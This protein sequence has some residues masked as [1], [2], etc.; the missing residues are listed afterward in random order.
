[1]WH[2]TE[3]LKLKEHA[4]GDGRAVLEN[5]VSGSCYRLGPVETRIYKA[6]NAQQKFDAQDMRALAMLA[7][8]SGTEPQTVRVFV[9]WLIQHGL[10]VSNSPS[11]LAKSE[12]MS[13]T[14]HSIASLYFL[15]VPLGIQNAG[16]K[17]CAGSRGCLP[18]QLT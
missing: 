6:I 11:Q 8:S 1:M 16:Y 5:I 14:L 10:L 12:R 2:I 18:G 9:H 4:S 3:Q 17:I 15:R 13:S 7:Q